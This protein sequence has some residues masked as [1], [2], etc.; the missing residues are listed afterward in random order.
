MKEQLHFSKFGEDFILF[1]DGNELRL[2]IVDDEY[3]YGY[4]LDVSETQLKY[5]PNALDAM[6]EKMVE[7]VKYFREQTS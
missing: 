3:G 6:C 5:I 7:D 4:D 1:S 2:R